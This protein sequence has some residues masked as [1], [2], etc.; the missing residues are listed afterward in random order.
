M[1]MTADE[2]IEAIKVSSISDEE[3]GRIMSAATTKL[4]ANAFVGGGLDMMAD[5]A[6]W[7]GTVTTGE[8]PEGCG[9]RGEGLRRGSVC[10]RDEGHPETTTNGGHRD[11]EGNLW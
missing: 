6:I 7:G 4:M 11:R 3:L 10:V 5:P 2:I 9:N 1:T 8:M